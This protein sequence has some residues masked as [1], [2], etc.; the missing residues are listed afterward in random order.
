[1]DVHWLSIVLLS[2]AANL[3]NLG[4]GVAYGVQSTRIPFL[5]NLA[6]AIIG[7][8]TTYVAVYLG[9]WIGGQIS[10]ELASIGGGILLI[11]IGAWT[12]WEDVKKNFFVTATATV[13]AEQEEDH[14]LQQILDNPE[15]ADFD[16]NQVITIKEAIVL[17]SALSLNCLGTGFGGGITGVSPLWLGV[18]V[19][20]V[21]FAT[22]GIGVHM[23]LKLTRPWMSKYANI[24]AGLILVGIGVY[25][26]LL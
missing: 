3:D 13:S 18:L 10:Q 20:I 2:T 24:I 7:A 9:G 21:S 5:S 19:G 11:L 6:I 15:K 16:K 22:I 17:G 1:M 4:I 12:I 8:V 26:V 25:E 23:G 14:F